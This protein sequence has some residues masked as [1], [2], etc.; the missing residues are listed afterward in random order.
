[1]KTMVNFTFPL[2]DIHKSATA[3][4]APDNITE[5]YGAP[6]A[7]FNAQI[8]VLRVELLYNGRST[9]CLSFRMDF[10]V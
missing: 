5:S 10:V 4:A 1:M 8:N 9:M 3:S 7:T 6:A 2:C